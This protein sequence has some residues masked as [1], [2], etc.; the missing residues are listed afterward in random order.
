MVLFSMFAALMFCSKLIMEVFPNIHLLGMLVMLLTVVFRKKALIP[1]YLYV[2]VQG[3]YA[4]FAPWWVPYLYVWTVLWGMTMLL[5][6]NM[7]IGV[8]AIVYPIVC[9]L[10]GFAFGIIYAPGQALLYGFTFEQTLAWIA[11]GLPFDVLH[12]ISN[13]FTGMLVL[14]LSEL[15]KKMLRQFGRN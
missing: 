10:H 13:I 11:S 5:P 12:G 1:I 9:S 14:P 7:P 8:K 3:L 4:G 6:K 2:I 15:I